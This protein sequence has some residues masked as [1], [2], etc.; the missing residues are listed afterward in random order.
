MAGNGRHA[1]L[2][3]QSRPS[4]PS[5]PLYMCVATTAV[6]A[7]AGISSPLLDWIGP[8]SPRQSDL[9]SAIFLLAGSHALPALPHQT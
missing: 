4:I 2:A 6:A 9:I 5:Y 8:N 3:G 1:F 7:L